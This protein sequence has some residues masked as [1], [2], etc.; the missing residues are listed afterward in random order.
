MIKIFASASIR[1]GGAATLSLEQLQAACGE[2]RRL[3]CRAV[4]HAHGPDS[5]IRAAQAGCT[6]I[7]HGALLDDAA[8]DTLAARR[9]FYDPNIGLVL[10]NYIDNKPKYLGIGNY[11]EEGFAQM[12]RAIPAGAGRVQARAASAPTSASCSART[13]WPA[14]MGATSRRSSTACRRAASR[15]WRRSRVGDLGGRAVARHAG[16]DRRRRAG[17]IA[18]LIATRGESRRGHHRAAARRCS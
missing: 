15:P 1:D 11:T 2:A 18:D 6:A 4:V 9:M 14:R 5:A 13:P 8:L 17:L 12:E 3:G 7:E 10:Q 16:L